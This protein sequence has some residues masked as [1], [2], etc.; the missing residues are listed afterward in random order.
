MSRNR[1]CRIH[2]SIISVLLC[3]TMKAQAHEFW[4]TPDEFAP[5]VN[6]PVTLSLLVGENF[7]GDP[8]GFGRPMAASFRWYSVRGDVQLQS[9]LPDNLF[10]S[11][12]AMAFDRPGAQLIALDTQPFTI[13]LTADKFSDYL[14]EEGLEHVMALREA[15]GQRANPGRERYRRHVKT[16]LNISGK[17]DASFGVRTG[18]TLEIVPIAN[19]HLLKPGGAL[20]LQILFKGLPLRGALL[21][22][23]SHQGSKLHMA[24][25]RTDVAGLGAVNIPWTGVWMLSVVHMVPSTDGE[26]QDWDSHWGNMTFEIPVNARLIGNGK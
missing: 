11:S 24:R 2:V 6:A 10:Q 19:P 26:G 1:R 14:R 18:Q 15:T 12:I 7:R 25:T 20:P 4:M 17:S 21:K 8:V 13:E 23:W 16:L 9:N 22:A 5:A 3:W